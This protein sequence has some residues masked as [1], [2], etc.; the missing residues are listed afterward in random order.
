MP[1]PPRH[2]RA[3]RYGRV[4]CAR[5]AARACRDRCHGVCRHPYE[6]I[7]ERL[8]S[9]SPRTEPLQSRAY[10]PAPRVPPPPLRTPETPRYPY[11]TYAQ[12]GWRPRPRA[13]S[14]RRAD[15]ARASRKN[16]PWMAATDARIA[17]SLG[18]EIGVR[19]AKPALLINTSRPPSRAT[20]AAIRPSAV[21]RS[22]RS[23]GATV[24]CAPFRRSS[25]AT[26]STP[27]QLRRVCSPIAVSG[28][29]RTRPIAAPVTRMRVRSG[30][31]VS[32][33]KGR[34]S[35]RIER[36]ET[37]SGQGSRD[38]SGRTAGQEPALKRAAGFG[39]ASQRVPCDGRVLTQ[40]RYRLVLAR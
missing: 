8:R 12:R 32:P 15:A 3:V 6:R 40:I 14:R 19:S 7:G 34:I 4:K 20:V 25:A 31:A 27:S 22:A 38:E 9:L 13:G 39:W 24:D 30:A 36:M 28:D 18:D 16:A 33:V 35:R 37:V 10:A 17:A 11:E 29:A 2:R 5:S 23:P 26:A 21:S 1:Q